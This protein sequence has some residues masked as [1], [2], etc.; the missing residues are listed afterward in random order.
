[1]ISWIY[2]KAKA[3]YCLK[4]YFHVPHLMDLA[5]IGIPLIV[6][7]LIYTVLLSVD[8]IMI[9]KM[10]G[11]KELGF[12]SIAIL[13]FTYTNT[14]PKLFG[15]V[16]FPSM[17]EELGKT[18]SVTGILHYVKKPVF[19][20]AHVF[21][22]ALAAAY[23]IIP[24]LV[25]YVLPRYTAGLVSMRILLIGCFFIS[26]AGFAQNLVIAR[27]RQ[28]LL[29]PFILLALIAGVGMNYILVKRG[30][31]IEGIAMGTSIAYLIYF[32]CIF[33]YVLIHAKDHK[34]ILKFFAQTCLPL[35]Y[36]SL[37]IL[38]LEFFI[39]FDFLILKN[40]VQMGIFAICYFPVLVYVQ[41]KTDILAHIK[42][43][44]RI[45]A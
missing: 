39:C 44:F 22:F 11:A 24:I 34:N 7:G 21:P 18:E 10:I 14:F 29:I 38:C 12:Y 23:F 40:S 30:F 36:A 2:V 35:V 1:M 4:W 6:I 41:K 3:G 5:K 20:M 16:L 43:M 32:L 15:I 13:A 45:N 25:G 9:I 8:R 42:K 17:Q 31:G 28:V 33:L 37:L 19:M 27:N 26:L